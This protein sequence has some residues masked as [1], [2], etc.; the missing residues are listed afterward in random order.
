MSKQS[1]RKSFET[2]PYG[3]RSGSKGHSHRRNTG[4][5][6]SGTNVNGNGGSN[7]A[8]INTDKVTDAEFQSH[9]KDRLLYLIMCSIGAHIRIA[10]N[11]GEYLEGTLENIDPTTMKVVIKQDSSVVAVNF[12]DFTDFEI[13]SVDLFNEAVVRNIGSFK[14]DSDISANKASAP[15]RGENIEKWVPEVGE[16]TGLELEGLTLEDSKTDNWDQFQTNERKF[17]IK[18]EFDEHM[19]TTKINKDDPNYK[20]NLEIADALAKDI[21]S[22]GHSGNAHLA[23]E[24]GVAFDDSG[25]DEEDKYSGVDRSAKA[26]SKGDAL[27]NSLMNKDSKNATFESEV[28]SKYIPPTQ[29]SRLEHIDPSIVS[30]SKVTSLQKPSQEQ[31]KPATI[32]SKPPVSTVKSSVTNS[33]S[34]DQKKNSNLKEI[35]SLKEFSQNFKIHSKIPEDL[36]PIITKDKQK[37]DEIVK[38]S[39]A[40]SKERNSTTKQNALP[41]QS[42][43]QESL[44]KV[45]SAQTSATNTPVSKKA[46]LS[47]C[48]HHHKLNAKAVPFTP[49]FNSSSSSPVVSNVS[50]P[51]FNVNSPRLAQSGYR[52]KRS[53]MSLFAPD[54]LPSVDKKKKLGDNFNFFKACR[55]EYNSLPKKDVKHP[56]TLER[57]FNTPPTWSDS[58]ISY[59]TFFPDPST[60]KSP[61]FASI[62][63]QQ[64]QPMPMMNAPG[65]FLYPPQPFMQPMRLSPQM[66]QPGLS[67]QPLQPMYIQP[68]MMPGAPMGYSGGYAR[69]YQVGGP[70][71][72]QLQQ[73]NPGRPHSYNKNH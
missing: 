67:V 5:S 33:K 39:E 72:M 11:S 27:F 21:E 28:K 35:N 69:G 6:G 50:T 25:I 32:P 9:Q 58:T 3:S 71:P 7:G 22:Q 16:S 38:K 29:R 59:R 17:G 54:K 8:V 2:Q 45:A 65:Q 34:Q 41:P 44:S 26:V 18:S 19:Y 55:A 36:L 56:F 53:H 20:K 70:V 48:K 66:A 47:S 68:G 1:N 12:E 42:Q 73:G 10:T 64:F 24:R 57:P 43:A 4:N 52:S 13:S 49:S 60:L 14:T 37:Q 62:P 40:E 46:E 63:Q 51:H 23:E 31:A 15:R 61:M 30:S